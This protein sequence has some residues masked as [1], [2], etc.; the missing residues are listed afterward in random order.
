[1]T[2][3]CYY[4]GTSSSQFDSPKARL[5]MSRCKGGKEKRREEEEENR[6]MQAAHLR[7]VLKINVEA[8][9]S[10]LLCWAVISPACHVRR[11]G[12]FFTEFFA[13]PRQAES[14]LGSR[15]RSC[16]VPRIRLCLIFRLSFRPLL[17]GEIVRKRWGSGKREQR[18][19]ALIWNWRRYQKLQ[20]GIR[21][22]GAHFLRKCF[23]YF[24]R[25]ACG[26]WTF[27]PNDRLHLTTSP[28][29]VGMV[30]RDRMTSIENKE[31][32]RERASS[33][34]KLKWLAQVKTALCGTEALHV[35][36]PV[37]SLLR[38]W[39]LSSA[40]Q[41]CDPHASLLVRVCRTSIEKSA[42]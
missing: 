20:N 24:S 40:Q 9:N 42:G 27:F 16:S 25:T 35:K 1:M 12:P 21:K 34:R 3:C 23:F 31:R 30:Q 4:F 18:I 33:T 37:G 13:N 5:P 10:A 32:E 11:L 39:P 29:L 41:I 6:L 19:F 7:P 22:N 38:R 2:S 14:G 15:G 28:K 36:R 26:K 8:S 17:F